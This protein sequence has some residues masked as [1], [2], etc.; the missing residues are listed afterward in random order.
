MAQRRDSINKTF[1]LETLRDLDISAKRIV[2]AT[3]QTGRSVDVDFNGATLMTVKPG[4]ETDNV[5]SDL[6]VHPKVI[7]GSSG[8]SNSM[9]A[10]L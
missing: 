9:N 3:R 8:R 5:L 6:Q 4:A 1:Q 2:Q 10:I 7:E